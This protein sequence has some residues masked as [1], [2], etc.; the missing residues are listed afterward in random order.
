MRP[1]E[2]LHSAS[3]YGVH[4]V[5]AENKPMKMLEFLRLVYER[6]SSGRAAIYFLQSAS[7]DMTTLMTYKGIS[8]NPF[9]TSCVLFRP[10]A[11]L[12]LMLKSLMFTGVDSS[13]VFSSTVVSMSMGCPIE[14]S[15]G[16]FS[17]FHMA[18]QF[19]SSNPRVFDRL[20]NESLLWWKILGKRAEEMR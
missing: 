11:G 15:D 8:G 1:L 7:I 10:N 20:R 5:K 9:K 18:Y 12:E 6:E 4:L 3:K 17:R 14:R 13:R 2:L 19:H 16:R